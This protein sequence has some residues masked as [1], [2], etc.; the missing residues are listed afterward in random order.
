[1]EAVP[2]IYL[3]TH[4][5]F[6]LYAEGARARL[7][8]AAREAVRVAEERRVSPMVRLELQYLYEIGRSGAPPA[9]ILDELDATLALTVCDAD[10]AAV[11]HAA[12]RLAWTRDPF[13]RLI[14]A[15][16]ALR[17]AALVTSDATIRANYARAVW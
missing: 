6:W 5:V 14:V 4:V 1:M 8:A 15:Q 2:L 11:V 9:V 10:F 17:G 12:E 3:D 7:S 16:A 13:D